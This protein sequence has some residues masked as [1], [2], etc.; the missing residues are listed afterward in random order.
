[1]EIIDRFKLICLLLFLE[2]EPRQLVSTGATLLCLCK[3]RL[4]AAAGLFFLLLFSRFLL[5]LLCLLLLLLFPLLLLEKLQSVSHLHILILDASFSLFNRHDYGVKALTVGEQ[6]VVPIFVQH[7]LVIFEALFKVEGQFALRSEVHWV[8]DGYEAMG[9]T[10]TT[11]VEFALAI[12]PGDVAFFATSDVEVDTT[13]DSSTHARA[14]FVHVSTL[15]LADQQID[16]GA[17][18]RE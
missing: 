2:N 11:Q 3:G 9:F 14:Y 4:L 13:S 12:G 7:L 15:F 1:M 17:I 16:E 10:D 5:F 8:N 6:W 18:S